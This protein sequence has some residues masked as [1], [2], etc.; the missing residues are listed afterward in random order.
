MESL[1]IAIIGATGVGK[2][3]FVQR[4]LGLTRPPISNA[5]SA[6]MVVDNVTYGVTLLELDLE[7]FD[8]NPS[9]PIQWPKQING[10]IVPRVDGALI[11]Y[12]V[13]NRDS[14]VELPETIGT[15]MLLF[16]QTS[17]ANQSAALTNSGLPAILVA[18]KCDNPETSRQVDTN[19]VA[20]HDLFKSCIA[21]YNISVNVP[22]SA[23]SCLAT[24][25]KAVVANRK[26]ECLR[27]E[28]GP[29]QS[30]TG[31]RLIRLSPYCSEHY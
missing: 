14:I 31:P 25:L 7:Y 11:L 1:N 21:T 2:S 19:G 24:I 16:N 13:M 27:I 8:M 29:V 9:Q 20:N 3:S 22:E 15:S 12:D 30:C 23:R 10:H 26:G 5:S 4:V 18:C 17:Y 6:R 28:I